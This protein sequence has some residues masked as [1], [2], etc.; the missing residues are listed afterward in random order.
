MADAAVLAGRGLV[1]EHDLELG[2]VVLVLVRPA[3]QV[4]DLVALDAAGAREHAEGADAGQVV[5]LEAED[6]A[7]LRGRDARLD[8]VLARMDVGDEALQPVGDELDRPAQQQADRHGREVV[9]V[10]VDL[11]AERAAHVLAQ[12]ADLFFRQAELATVQVLHHVRRLEAVPHGELAVTRVPVGD[13]A[14]R[15]ERHAGVAAEDIGLLE[16]RVGLRKGC[17]H[18]ADVQLALEA[19]VVAQL[20]VDHRRGRVERGLGVHDGRQLLPFDGQVLQRVL[21]LHARLGRDRDHRLALP[22]R[23]VDRQRVLGRALDAGQVRQRGDPGLA[24]AREIRAGEHA[25]HARHLAGDRGVDADDAHVRDRRAPIDHVH[26]ARQLDVVDVLA[27]A[28]HQA[29][30]AVARHRLADVTLILGDVVELADERCF[31]GAVHAV[32]SAGRR[33]ALCKASTSQTAST[34][35]W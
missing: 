30:H 28:L 14:A 23:A 25:D 16:D 18:V 21:G 20:R 19:Q 24:E 31:P 27:A 34:I 1:L 11:D 33:P 12:H 3:G 6:L 22:D 17:V 13:L 15:L 5:D 10:G 9:G 8:A 2:T 29:S 32:S 35:A 4:D 7:V 26:H